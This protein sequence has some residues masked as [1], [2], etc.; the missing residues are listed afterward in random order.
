MAYRRILASPHVLA[1]TVASVVARLPVGMTGVAFVIY[2][3]DRTDSFGAAGAAAG[4]FTI[5][6]AL[7]APVLGR[8][9][10]RRG[11]RPVLVPASALSAAALVGVVAVGD[12]GGGTA[13]V[14]A[15]AGLAGAAMPPVGGLLRHLWPELVE[16]TCWSTP[17]SSTRS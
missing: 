10:D 9:V 17:T 14:V 8:L 13:A 3:H 6:L 7:T 12:A 16:E 11:P 1:L 5:G 4:A 2:I 15:L